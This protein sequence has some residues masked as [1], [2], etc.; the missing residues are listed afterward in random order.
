MVDKMFGEKVTGGLLSV[1]LWR[2][3]HMLALE[4]GSGASPQF[5]QRRHACAP[6]RFM[7]VECWGGVQ[8]IC[9][10]DNVFRSLDRCIDKAAGLA[11]EPLKLQAR[12]MFSNS[13]ICGRVAL[14]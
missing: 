6:R 12:K 5:S 8:D 3:E 14:A 10:C 7:G 9:L 2:C 11:L 13:T 4:K 1:S